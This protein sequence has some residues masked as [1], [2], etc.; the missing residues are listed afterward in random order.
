MCE[1]LKGDDLSQKIREVVKGKDAR[2]AVAFWGREAVEELFGKEVLERDDVRIVCDLS[3]GGTNPATLRALGA[4]ENPNIKYLDG[5]HSKVFLSDNGAIV[6]SANASN[7]GIGFMGGN[8]QLLEAGTYLAPESD[9][10]CSINGWLGDLLRNRS[11]PVDSQ[12]LNAARLAWNR[13]RG[14]GGRRNAQ[15]QPD[16]L[17]YDPEVHGLVLVCWYEGGKGQEMDAPRIANHGRSYMYFSDDRSEILDHWICAFALDGEGRPMDPND[18]NPSFFYVTNFEENHAQDATYYQHL[19][20]QLAGTNVS[21]SPFA[22][23]NSDFAK[24]FCTVVDWKKY[25]RL[26]DERGADDWQ[27]SDHVDEMCS[28]WRDVQDEYRRLQNQP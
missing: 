28:F 6:G 11:K 2:C 17:N 15:D 24:A 14:A 26:R 19:A 9:A 21:N 12:A 7:N 3:M 27:V 10:W 18:Q 8:A 16:F 23:K 4:P 25:A 1:F 20:F 22:V 5:L 13:R